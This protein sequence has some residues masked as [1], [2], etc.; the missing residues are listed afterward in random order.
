VTACAAA[1]K[2]PPPDWTTPREQVSS[3]F[4]PTTRA[5]QDS[6]VPHSYLFLPPPSNLPI[7]PSSFPRSPPSP[8]APAKDSTYRISQTDLPS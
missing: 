1:N 7:P 8:V 6:K 4:S 2:L 5:L 3:V